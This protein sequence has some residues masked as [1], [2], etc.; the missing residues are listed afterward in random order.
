LPGSP[1]K[2]RRL[3]VGQEREAQ[4]LLKKTA[5]A[6]VLTGAAWSNT[7]GQRK[8]SLMNNVNDS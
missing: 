4:K 2:F 8:G 7:D 1:K 5:I 3:N 6:V